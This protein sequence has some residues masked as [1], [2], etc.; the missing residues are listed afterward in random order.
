MST[1][2]DHERSGA[3]I[4]VRADGKKQKQKV[5]VSHTGMFYGRGQDLTTLKHA[6]RQIQAPKTCGFF[7]RTHHE[8]GDAPPQLSAQPVDDFYP[9]NTSPLDPPRQQKKRKKLR[10]Y[11]NPFTN[12]EKTKTKSEADSRGKGEKRHETPSNHPNFV[13][14]SKYIIRDFRT[15]MMRRQYGTP[16]AACMPSPSPHQIFH[17]SERSLSIYLI[18]SLLSG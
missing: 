5:S 2:P 7:F 16:A 14:S 1:R 17:T 9:F 3:V 18:D 15:R 6:H 8:T 11:D 12:K 10:T 4:L 13:P